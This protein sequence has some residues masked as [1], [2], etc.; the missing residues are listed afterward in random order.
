MVLEGQTKDNKHWRPKRYLESAIV[1]SRCSPGLLCCCAQSWATR[2]DLGI[3]FE[4]GA[5]FRWYPQKV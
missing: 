1:G 4:A 2:T 3:L 5:G